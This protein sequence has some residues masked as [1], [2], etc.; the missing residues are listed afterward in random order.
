MNGQQKAS[1]PA[2]NEA[3][4][5]GHPWKLI[6]L[7][8]FAVCAFA[9]LIL[10]ARFDP[11]PSP[12]NWYIYLILLASAAGGFVALLPGAI[13]FDVP[14]SIKASGALAVFALVFYFGSNKAVPA[15]SSF[16]MNVYLIFGASAPDSPQESDVVV[17]VNSKVAKVVKADAASS[18]Q[19][20]LPKVEDPGRD[21]TIEVNRSPAGGFRI[22]FHKLVPGD[23]VRA[24]V[25]YKTTHWQSGDYVIPEGY[26]TMKQVSSSTPP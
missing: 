25:Y 3:E 16:S 18:T 4:Q 24:D 2:P 9:I 7:F 23:R 20:S 10:V 19:L 21:S 11:N 1:S 17:V 8:A 13:N 14:G 5:Q 22:D 26:W 6:T 15:A 12:T